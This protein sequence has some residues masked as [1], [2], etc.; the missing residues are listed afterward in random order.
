MSASAPPLASLF[1]TVNDSVRSAVKSRHLFWSPQLEKASC[2]IWHLQV[3]RWP[4]SKV[5]WTPFK[6]VKLL[7]GCSPFYRIRYWPCTAEKYTCFTI[8]SRKIS[9]HKDTTQQSAVQRK[10]HSQNWDFQQGFFK[11]QS[12]PYQNNLTARYRTLRRRKRRRMLT[13][14]GQ[15]HWFRVIEII[16]FVW[17]G[18]RAWSGGKW[19]CIFRALFQST[20]R[21]KRFAT[22]TH[23]HTHSYTDGGGC[24]ARRQLLIRSNLGLS[25]FDTQLEGA[26]IGAIDL[27]ITRRP[28]L[29]PELHPKHFRIRMAKS[30][31]SFRSV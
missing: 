24:H 13:P 14:G 12:V 1:T 21:S 23:S 3:Y 28:A 22:F 6:V 9:Q 18:V 10:S 8:S 17:K 5:T 30:M 27:P 25:I 4:S 11:L 19:S 16:I 29:P 15:V 20:D 26:G 2:A 7:L 31:N